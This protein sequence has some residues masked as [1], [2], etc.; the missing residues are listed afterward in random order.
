MV[1]KKVPEA[2]PVMMLMTHLGLF[3]GIRFAGVHDSFWTHACDVDTMN[4]VLRDKFVDLYSQPILEDTCSFFRSSYKTK[5]KGIPINI[6]NV[7][8]RG[9]LDLNKIRD[10]TYF[11]S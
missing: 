1:C 8:E 9:T 6:P 7:P 11:F 4:S 3:A 2:M 5:R 10:S